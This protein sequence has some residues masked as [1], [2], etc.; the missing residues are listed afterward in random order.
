MVF[1]VFDALDECDQRKGLLP[2]LHRMGKGGAN[3]FVTSRQH[4]EDIQASFHSSAKIKL[5]AQDND[6]RIYI[7]QK[8]SEHSRARRLV[9]QARCQDKIVSELIDCAQGM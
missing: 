8:I 6:I 5:S 1:L 9:Q 4:P 3:L 2:L 7:E